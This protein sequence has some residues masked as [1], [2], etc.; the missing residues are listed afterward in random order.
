M[1]QTVSSCRDLPDFTHGPGDM[2]ARAVLAPRAMPFIGTAVCG[3]GLN[4][5]DAAVRW[6]P[7]YLSAA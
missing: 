7:A 5:D 3:V 6:T 4:G 1:R 2:H